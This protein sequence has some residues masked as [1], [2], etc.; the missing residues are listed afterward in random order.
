MTT[1]YQVRF[2][3]IAHW[4]KKARPYGVRWVTEGKQHSEWFVTKALANNR[5]SQLMQAARAGEAFDVESGLPASEMRRRNSAT[6]V[7][8]AQ[9]YV[10][11]KWPDQAANSRRST[12]DALATA[13]A[14]FVVD[15]PARPSVAALRRMLTVHVLPPSDR[16][17][18]IGDEDRLVVDW[19]AKSSRPVGDLAEASAARELLDGLARNLDG[20]VAAATV[21]GRKRAVVHN[22]LAFA[23]ERELLVSNPVTHLRW[24]RPK[25]VEQVDPRVVINPRQARELFVVLSY[26]GRR[27]ATRGAHLVGFFA[28]IYYSAARPAEMINIRE[29]DCKLPETGWGELTLWESRPAAGSR[30]TD[31]GEVH[32]RRGLKHRAA[33]EARIVPI[34]PALVLSLR[35]HIDRFGVG[36]DGR[37][38][39]SPGG[40]VVGS[41]TYTRVWHA[42]RELALTPAQVA[43][44]L[45]ARPYDLRHAAVSTWLNAGVPAAEV[46]ERAGHSVDVLNKVYAKCLDGQR[47]AINERISAVLGSRLG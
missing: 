21:I 18:E 13:C 44:P 8:L 4:K 38:F 17:D 24:K 6:L 22:L 15:G 46:A 23:V 31:S 29:T 25:R 40:G 45:A 37:L 28:G 47:D 14:A 34:P 20:K 2:W 39:R 16:R 1:T 33:R 11:M 10:A 43:S 41:A 12:V 3:E 35:E 32:D 5:R 30:W 42:A 19:L 27:N 36:A 7:Q 26:V 9:E